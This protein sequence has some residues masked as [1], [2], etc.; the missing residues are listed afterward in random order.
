MLR[1]EAAEN[2]WNKGIS[3]ECRNQRGKMSSE[4]TGISING[5]LFA[6]FCPVSYDLIVVKRLVIQHLLPKIPEH[7][8][9]HRRC[10]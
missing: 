6:I 9:V 10:I 5:L 2:T 8:E 3:P 1:S 7:R 4:S